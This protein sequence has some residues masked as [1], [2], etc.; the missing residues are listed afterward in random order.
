MTKPLPIDIN[1]CQG[2]MYFKNVITKEKC[3]DILKL[4]SKKWKN[5]G[6]GAPGVETVY[7]NKIRK[8]DI[9]FI[10]EQWLYK[11][12]FEIV[13]HTNIQGQ[14][15][16]DIDGVEVVQLTRYHKGDYFNWHLDGNGVLETAEGKVRKLS[17]TI[18]LNDDYEGGE[19]E[20]FLDDIQ[21]KN[22][23]GT[24]IVFPSY[25]CHRVKPVTKGTRYSLVAW[26]R[27][28]KFI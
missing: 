7:D 19:F 16:F 15:N 6:V 28:P 2:W 24:V 21:I 18:I 8:S 27:G 23:I 26:F 3:E 20:F 10:D 25:F 14:W 22:E 17:M 9:A 4:A 1:P 12:V 13:Q 5:G 11:D